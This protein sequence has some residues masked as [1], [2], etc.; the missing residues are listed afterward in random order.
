MVLKFEQTTDIGDDTFTSLIVQAAPPTATGDEFGAL[1]MTLDLSG[2]R[3]T[4]HQ[5]PVGTAPNPAKR[6]RPGRGRLVE[7]Q[8]RLARGFR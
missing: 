3:A 5:Q 6:Q 7:G 8:V 2:A 4:Y 1:V